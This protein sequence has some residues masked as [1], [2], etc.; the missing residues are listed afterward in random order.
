MKKYC[1]HIRIIA[2]TQVCTGYETFTEQFLEFDFGKIRMCFWITTNTML[3]QVRILR[4]KF[5]KAH[6][7][8]IQ[9]NGGTVS[10]KVDWAVSH[11]EKQIPLDSVFAQDEM[12]D[13][14]GV[15]KG[16]GMKGE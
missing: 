12:I 4:K 16:K 1:T 13:V 5:K 14:I 3:Q 2:H 6:I 8:E 11:F 7:M 9:L 10:E 15:T